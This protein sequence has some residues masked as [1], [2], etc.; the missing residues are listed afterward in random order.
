MWE[1]I[2][3]NLAGGLTGFSSMLPAA[4]SVFGAA[5]TFKMADSVFSP[6]KRKR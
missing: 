6:L 3:G 2:K 5:L 4:G 1:N